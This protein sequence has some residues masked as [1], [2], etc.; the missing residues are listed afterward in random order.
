MEFFAKTLSYFVGHGQ[1]S[2]LALP[3][4]STDAPIAGYNTWATH[5]DPPARLPKMNAAS[6]VLK[7]LTKKGFGPVQ[8]INI[9]AGVLDRSTNPDANRSPRCH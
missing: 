2:R 3:N 1:Q 9:D 4:G 6:D 5:D 8:Y 7:P